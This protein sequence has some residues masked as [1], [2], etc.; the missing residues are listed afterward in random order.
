MPTGA[1]TE[2]PEPPRHDHVDGELRRLEEQLGD[3]L[4]T[5][6]FYELMADEDNWQAEDRARLS[7]RQRAERARRDTTRHPATDL[8]DP[9]D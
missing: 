8:D 7:A 2:Y 6:L 1:M 3:S 9:A 4:R 5:S